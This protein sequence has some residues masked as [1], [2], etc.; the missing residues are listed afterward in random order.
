MDGD[1]NKVNLSLIF[2][3]IKTRI[4]SFLYIFLP[5]AL[6]AI[7]LSSRNSKSYKAD[8]NINFINNSFKENKLYFSHHKKIFDSNYLILKLEDYISENYSSEKDIEDG[9]ENIFN[10][11][12][13]K[14]L[15]AEEEREKIIR[16]YEFP[17]DNTII[18]RVKSKNKNLVENLEKDIKKYLKYIT[19]DYYKA[20]NKEVNLNKTVSKERYI[21]S[22]NKL[23]YFLE[24]YNAKL[25]LSTKGRDIL[26]FMNTEKYTYGQ[27]YFVV[28]P[29]LVNNLD[30]LSKEDR[31]KILTDNLNYNDMPYLKYLNNL[32]SR[33]LSKGE[34]NSILYYLYST[35]FDE[36]K[37]LE[38]NYILAERAS[39]TLSYE[40]SLNELIVDNYY[41]SIT[42]KKI[43]SD[44]LRNYFLYLLFATLFGS[45]YLIYDISR[46]YEINNL[47]TI[48]SLVKFKFL[49]FIDIEKDLD[50]NI[51]YLRYIN[52]NNFLNE[53]KTEIAIYFFDEE[54]NFSNKSILNFIKIYFGDRK[55]KIVNSFEDTFTYEDIIIVVNQKNITYKSINN[56]NERFF[57]CSDKVIGWISL[58]YS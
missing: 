2:N 50:L 33:K 51:K 41:T 43:E 16:R 31:E 12:Y 44:R 21:E 6:I 18:V 47:S 57:E 5:I 26:L 4:K 9:K 27:I 7:P 37:I 42:S 22:F 24:N 13:L 40:K 45:T 36:M 11:E 54:P 1:N 58:K 49:D 30:F 14:V 52:L 56:L 23:K 38:D 53:I 34:I 35:Y 55:Y 10:L 17:K 15:K 48:K 8:I 29:K 32:G 25:K 20:F 19:D 46:N 39:R 28:D 3:P